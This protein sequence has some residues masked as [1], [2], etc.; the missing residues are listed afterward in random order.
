MPSLF[1]KNLVTKNRHDLH[2]I[3]LTMAQRQ[4]L[5]NNATFLYQWRSY[6]PFSLIVIYF[7]AL[8]EYTYPRGDEI[9]AHLWTIFCLLV[10]FIGIF[11]RVTTIGQTPKENFDFNRKG[12]TVDNLYAKGIY[13]VVR[14]PIYLG[15][16]FIG[17][18]IVLFVHL[19]WLVVVY[20]LIFWI[21]YDHIIFIEEQFL[22]KKFGAY[23][24]EW[25]ISI[26]GLFP[27]L[28][29]YQKSNVSFSWQ[30]AIIKEYN[31]F[32]STIA[33]M[34]ILENI[35]E[36]I[37]DDKFDIESYWIIILS[38]SFFVWISLNIYT[39]FMSGINKKYR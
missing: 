9:L 27:K 5:N 26:P 2:Q 31:S 15:N 20:I 7:C 24:F 3:G 21:Y 17:L 35:G 12:R 13:S 10:S 32:V 34:F 29:N 6:L 28:S 38:V 39:K 19:W 8:D 22:R 11:I 16:F 14:N 18:G 33:I 37:V 36:Q 1:W 23:F 25:A 30:N 4:A